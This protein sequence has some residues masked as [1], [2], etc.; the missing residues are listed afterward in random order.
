MTRAFSG[1]GV[2]DTGPQGPVKVAGG[3]GRRGEGGKEAWAAPA[4][5]TLKGDLG[6][7]RDL[8]REERIGEC[9][10][11]GGGLEPGGGSG[12][13]SGGGE[14]SRSM[15]RSSELAD[16]AD[17]G[18]RVGQEDAGTSQDLGPGRAGLGSSPLASGGQR[19]SWSGRK[20]ESSVPRGTQFC[21][22][23]QSQFCLST[24]SPQPPESLPHARGQRPSCP[25]LCLHPVC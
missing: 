9:R 10:L 15:F 19:G 3:G 25:P 20:R 13:G 18:G 24:Q 8:C 4:L 2:W 14:S 16:R 1:E 23:T 6:S 5:L 22:S 7:R 11:E 21:L 12:G 17:G